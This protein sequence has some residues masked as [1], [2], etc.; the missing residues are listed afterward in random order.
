[1]KESIELLTVTNCA[2]VNLRKKPSKNSEVL[3]ILP[4]DSIVEKVS[5]NVEG[6]TRVKTVDNTIGFVMNDYLVMK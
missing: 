4:K 3:T 6:W 1:M 5:S 2:A